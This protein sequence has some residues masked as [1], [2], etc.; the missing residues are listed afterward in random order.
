MLTIKEETFLLNLV[1]ELNEN[2]LE[3]AIRF[4]FNSEVVDNVILAF[5]FLNMLNV[6]ITEEMHLIIINIMGKK[7]NISDLSKYDNLSDSVVNILNGWKQEKENLITSL[8]KNIKM[9][10][11][12]K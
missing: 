7:Q 12:N 11:K 2:G 10:I 1:D 8:I 4:L 6:E 9:D 5:G 3:S